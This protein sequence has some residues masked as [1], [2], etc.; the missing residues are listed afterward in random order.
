MEP[1]GDS[2][3][4]VIGEEWRSRRRPLAEWA[5]ERLV[6]RKDVWG[7][8]TGRTE[9]GY[10]ALTLPQKDRRGKDMITLNK[11]MRHFGSLQ[12]RHL[13][14][15]HSQNEEEFSKWFAVD[16]DLHDPEAFD[17]PE[18]AG[19]N[20]TAALGWWEKLTAA[21]YDPLLLD[22]NGAG[23]F[24]LLVLLRE[25]APMADVYGFAQDLVSDWQSRNLDEAPETFPKS[26]KLGEDKLGVWLRLPG[27]HHTRDHFTR[28]WSGDAWLDN[29]WLEGNEAIDQILQTMPG[30]PPPARLET[31][32]RQP[33]R[34]RRAASTA[35]TRPRVCVDLDGVLAR[36]D[37][38][39]GVEH[40]GEP[41]PGAIEFT[42]DLMEWADVIIFT[43]RLRADGGK[44]PLHEREK[45]V[46]QWLDEHGFRYAEVYAG[47]GKPTA[48]A[49]IDD[50]A[51][52][53]NPQTEGPAAFEV[54]A[55]AARMLS[56]R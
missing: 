39:R 53:C 16:I 28:V 3:L 32:A 44:K 5:F 21:G 26:D 8:Y 25:L 33:A 35:R 19:R 17:A 43:S 22:S 24:H 49:Y 13:I 1:I 11:L 42:R 4:Q 14:G 18:A 2:R 38:W 36:Y 47:Q 10:K 40:F 6:H 7:Q 29:P 12:R 9:K 45:L 54:A 15:L 46:R 56:E 41:L 48:S 23:G 55:R 52:S 50:R 31:T 27:L 51:V 30:P 20:Q 37:G 34:K